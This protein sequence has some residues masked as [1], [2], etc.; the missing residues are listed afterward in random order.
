MAKAFKGRYK[1]EAMLVRVHVIDDLESAMASGSHEEIPKILSIYRTYKGVEEARVFNL[2]GREV[3]TEEK[4]PNETMVEE[5]L[6]T[7]EIVHFDKEINRGKVVSYLIPIR[8][9]PECYGCHGKSEALRGGLLLL[10]H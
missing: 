4:G 7:G 10:C 9:K 8:N 2:K 1:E 3:F 5:M 6:R